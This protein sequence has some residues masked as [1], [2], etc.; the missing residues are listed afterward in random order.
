[1]YISI[2]RI[3]TVIINCVM[4]MY[5]YLVLVPGYRGTGDEVQ[6][7]HLVVNVHIFDRNGNV[8]GYSMYISWIRALRVGMHRYLR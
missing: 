2:L 4:E 8:P 7:V 6:I 5:A 3:L 1:M